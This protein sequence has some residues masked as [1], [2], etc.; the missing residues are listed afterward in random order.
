[1]VSEYYSLKT[2]KDTKVSGL[3]TKNMATDNIPGQTG[4]LIKATT[5]KGKETGRERWSIKMESNTM[6]TGL[7]AINMEMESTVQVL[8]SSLANGA[9]ASSKEK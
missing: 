1:M 2:D 8:M 6:A 3:L 9:K 5:R 4:V 7:K